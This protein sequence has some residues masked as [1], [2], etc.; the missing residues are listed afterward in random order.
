MDEV[1][2]GTQKNTAGKPKKKYF[3]RYLSVT[4][5]KFISLNID[6][7]DNATISRIEE[8]IEFRGAN[9]WILAFAIIIASIGLN[10]NS[11]AVIIGAMLISPLMGPIMGIGLAVGISDN[12]MLSRSLRN[13]GAM[14][15]I[16]IIASTLYFFIS[17][18]SDAQSELLARTRPTIYDVLI[19]FF[20]G[21]AGIVAHSRKGEKITI[22]SGVAIATALM[23]P[24]CTAGYG[25]ATAQ[26]NF[27]FGAFYL[28]F[29]NSFFIAL[30]TVLMSYYLKLPKRSFINP[31]KA[32]K[33]KR[34]IYIFTTIV[35]VPSIFM[36]VNMIQESSFNSSAIRFMN[37]LDHNPLLENVQIINS[38]REYSR[39]SSTIT[40]AL[41]GKPLEE[42]QI[43]NLQQKLPE[44]GLKNTH[45]IIRQLMSDS[46]ND[47]NISGELMEDLYK[48][49]VILSDQITEY[50][51]EIIQLQGEIIP[52]EQ[53]AKEIQ[54]QF[55]NIHS[56]SI[57]RMIYTDI[58]TLTS[59][60]IPTAYVIW[61]KKPAKED[62]ER[63][64]NWL[65]ARLNL[66]QLK[67]TSSIYTKK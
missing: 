50:K 52:N 62:A 58:Q 17:P 14:V 27:F 26:F 41:V 29:I 3:L 63:L 24:L 20:G 67:L 33:V 46:D 9:V 30:A 61:L 1:N 60:T 43:K 7:D 48:K 45:L 4:I 25:L 32:K 23:P 40:I 47:I 13:F 16:S 15:L 5:K 28:F 51:N 54:T 56:F 37:D 22:I 53:I 12:N 38:S 42:K 65:K 10:V 11:T 57:S 18:L 35:C 19:A 39:D 6:S 2:T 31:Q 64:E 49:N 36:A 44:F 34:S 66:D 8:G 21:L 59:D 55:N